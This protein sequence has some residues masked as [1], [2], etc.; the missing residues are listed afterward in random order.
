YLATEKREEALKHFLPQ[1]LQTYLF[2]LLQE[3]QHRLR[4]LVGLGQDRGTGLLQDLVL[5]QCSGFGGVVGILDT[6]FRCRDVFADVLQVGDSV[7]ETV[8]HRTKLGTLGV[9]LLDGIVNYQHRSLCAGGVADVDVFDTTRARGNLGGVID[10]YIRHSSAGFLVTGTI[11]K[12]DTS[13]GNPTFGV[14]PNDCL[15]VAI[16]ILADTDTNVGIVDRRSNFIGHNICA[17]TCL[18]SHI[19]RY[20]SCGT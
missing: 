13:H 20:G 5:A 14:S 6:A 19:D 9:D 8:L 12:G 2:S 3:A 15:Q 18:Q 10:C 17:V 11:G 16:F 1:L 4:Q 7:L